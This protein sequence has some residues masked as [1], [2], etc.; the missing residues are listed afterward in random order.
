VSFSL[1]LSFSFFWGKDAKCYKFYGDTF[2][3]I[4]SELDACLSAKLGGQNTAT[5]EVSI[6]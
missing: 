2:N 5:Q 1:F 6:L 4:E 3:F